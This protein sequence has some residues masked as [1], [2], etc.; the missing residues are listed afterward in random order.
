MQSDSGDVRSHL[1][2]LGIFFLIL[3]IVGFV[4]GLGYSILTMIGLAADPS[5]LQPPTE[6][7]RSR[8]DWILHWGVRRDRL[9][10]LEFSVADHCDRGRCVV[11]EPK[12][13]YDGDL[14]INFMLAALRFLAMLCCRCPV[15]RVGID[16][17]PVRKRETMFLMMVAPTLG[18]S[19]DSGH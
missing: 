4:G 3:G 10:V 16:R 14:S 5:R 9:D 2:A 7:P 11:V 17:A 18:F 15:R 1:K 6:C 13:T 12:R 19:R 8:K